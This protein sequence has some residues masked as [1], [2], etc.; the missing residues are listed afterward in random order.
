MIQQ[1]TT[2][3]TQAM[4]VVRLSQND[5]LRLILPVPESAVSS[6][7]VGEPVEVSVSALQRSF[8]GRIR[9]FEDKVSLST[10]TM[11]TEVDVPNPDYI[12]VPGMYAE[13]KLRLRQ[14][15]KVLSVPLDAMEES[16]DTA[17]VYTV[18]ESAIHIVTVRTGLKTSRQEEIRSGLDEGEMVVIGRHAGLEEGQKVRTKLANFDDSS[19]PGQGD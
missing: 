8:P 9:R 3:A 10:R 15:Q 16:N 17:R 2:S 1:G 11:N 6:I 7:R 5:L 12:L 4:P 13:I 18:K 19:T 14:S